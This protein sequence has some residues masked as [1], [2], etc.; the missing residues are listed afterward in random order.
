MQGAWLPS[1]QI[2]RF[3]AEAESG[4][5]PRGR[6]KRAAQKDE[7]PETSQPCGK[8]LESVKFSRRAERF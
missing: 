8:S 4:Q 1:P 7:G 6:C 3:N 2:E 5:W